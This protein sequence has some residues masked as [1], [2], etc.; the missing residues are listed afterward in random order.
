VTPIKDQAPIN[1]SINKI[2][3]WGELNFTMALD[4]ASLALKHR[5]NKNQRQRLVA[6][7]AS[8]LRETQQDLKN[9]AKKARRN[10]IAIDIIN[11]GKFF[12]GKP[13]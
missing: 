12:L 9:V 13:Q 10:N 6:M 7:I 3:I 4:I 5:C 11:L 8:P 1:A 2:K